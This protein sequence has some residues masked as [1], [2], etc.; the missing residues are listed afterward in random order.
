[1]ET[2]KLTPLSEDERKFHADWTKEDCLS[3]LRRIAEIDTTQVITRNYFRVHS[4][5]SESTWNRF[6]GTFAEFKR[7]ANIVL[8]RHAHRLELNIAK[9][10]SVDKLR[11]LNTEKRQWAG[12]YLRPTTGRWET[13]IVVSD[14]HGLRCDPYVRRVLIETIQR[15]QP[16][17]VVINGD[18]MDLPEFSKHTQDPRQFEVVKEIQWMH[19]LL[20]DIRRAAPNTEIDYV[21]G[22]HEFRLLRHMAEETPALMV[23]LAELHDFTVA[24]I[25]GLDK[26]E[27]NYIARADMTAWNER[28]IKEQLRKNYIVCWDALLFGHYPEMQKMGLPGANGH[29]HKY[30]A[31]SHYSPTYGPYQW[32]QTGCAHVREASYCAAE[33]W[34]EGFLAVHVD[35]QTKRSQFEYFDLSHDGAFVG[36]LFYERTAAE[37]VLDLP[38]M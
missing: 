26:F 9:H 36:G 35:T 30:L 7:Q 12:K 4:A 28:D 11:V 10:A 15:M 29:H 33:K 38:A 23:V 25:F 13:A 14:L 17:K 19:R 21:E 32:V 3:E 22:N 31:S 8:S 16:A 6:F 20:A 34:S 37:R 5:I 2:V 24:K 1:M 18:G 27:V